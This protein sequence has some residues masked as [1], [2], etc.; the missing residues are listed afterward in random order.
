MH[1][2]DGDDVTLLMLSDREVRGLAVGDPRRRLLRGTARGAPGA[3]RAAAR[4]VSM[5]VTWPYDV[6]RASVVSKERNDSLE[7]LRRRVRAVF[8]EATVGTV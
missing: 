4:S 7:V 3:A 6:W 1:L 2:A 8:P 5:L